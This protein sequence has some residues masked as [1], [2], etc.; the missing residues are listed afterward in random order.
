MGK[1][2]LVPTPLHDE[3]PL[4][5][6]ARELLHKVCMEEKTTL[7]VEEH[8]EGRRRW[9]H[10]GLPR[11]AIEKFIV[12]NEHSHTKM[13]PEI[14]KL[15]KL[16]HQVFLLSDCGLPAFCDPGQSLVHA[17]HEQNI[18]VTSTPFPNA[19]ALAVA[20][21]GFHHDKF[22]FQ[23]FLP[24][25]GEERQKAIQE[26]M[27]IKETQVLMDTPY[28]L[29]QLMDELVKAEGTSKKKRKAFLALN[30]NSPEEKLLQGSLIH[31]QNLIKGTEKAEFVILLNQIK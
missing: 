10:W 23:G 31:I 22:I 13:M 17:A 6:V 15:L 30:L 25:R 19:I 7:L 20:L 9:L 4:E 11:E 24:V 18:Q 29:A 21:S 5:T 2:I 14:L 3:L 1:L 12:Y 27:E 16:G 8:K 28:R 26:V